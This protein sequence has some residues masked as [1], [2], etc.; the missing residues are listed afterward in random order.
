[1]T[2]KEKFLGNVET[3][4]DSTFHVIDLIGVNHKPHTFTIGPRH[5]AYAS[6]YCGGMLGEDVMR[7]VPCAAKRCKLSY[8]E[9]T[10]DMV[11]FLRLKRNLS[12]NEA[13]QILMEIIEEAKKL[14]VRLDGFTF[15]ESD[16]N[17]RIGGEN[18]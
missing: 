1:M 10:Y 17:Y 9:H 16:G 12:Q 8:D 11:L 6:K 14:N 7:K 18:D 15:V 4:T 3:I 5:V 13:K 2:D